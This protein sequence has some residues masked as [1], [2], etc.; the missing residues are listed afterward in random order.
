MKSYTFLLALGFMAYS[1]VS[2]GCDVNDQRAKNWAMRLNSSASEESIQEA[3]NLIDDVDAL[4]I[5]AQN[6]ISKIAIGTVSYKDKIGNDGLIEKAIQSS[7]LH[8][9]VMM[10]VYHSYARKGMPPDNIRI[11]TYLQGLADLTEKGIYGTVSLV[12]DQESMKLMRITQLDNSGDSFEVEIQ[13]FQEFTACKTADR[14]YCYEDVTDKRFIV[15]VTGKT[16]SEPKLKIS[17]ITAIDTWA[18][19]YFKR[20]RNNLMGGE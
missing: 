7:F 14:N 19:D 4:V 20:N 9:G 1:S 11:R 17:R 18:A 3:C 8:G 6:T 13:A 2:T 12:Y 10:Q 15:S 16:S 5:Q